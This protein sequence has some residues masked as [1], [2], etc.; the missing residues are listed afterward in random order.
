MT[1]SFW[2]GSEAVERIERRKKM[3]E[4]NRMA[5]LGAEWRDFDRKYWK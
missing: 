1:A 4:Q 3:M 5:G 2:A